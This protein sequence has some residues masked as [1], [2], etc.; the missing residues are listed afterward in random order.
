M[1]MTPVRDVM[2]PHVHTIDRDLRVSVAIELMRSY[3]IRRLPVIRA[4][5]RKVIGI[6][7]LGEAQLAMPK[8]THLAEVTEDIPYVRD[9]MTDYVYTIGPDEPV[10]RAAQL[11][12]N[13]RISCLPVLDE[14]GDLI[15]IV[16]E[17]D[18]FK[19]LAYRLGPSST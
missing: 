8:D 7:S 12:V 19:Y 9:V 14:K 10:A 13:H 16:T 2:T 3:G 11:M 1:P 17:S 5:T 6:L 4:G 18:L 15:G